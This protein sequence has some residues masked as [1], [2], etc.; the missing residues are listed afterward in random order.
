MTAPQ[1]SVLLPAEADTPS[2]RPP[3]RR[4]P[5]VRP[6]GPGPLSAGRQT[7]D[8]LLSTLRERQPDLHA[9]LTGVADTARGGGARAGHDP[10]R[11]STRSRGPRSC[12]TSARW[13]SPT[14]SCDKPGPL[15]DEEWT[16]HAP[17]HDH[18]RAHPRRGP[19]LVPVAR[20]VRSSHERWDGAGYPDGLAGEEIPL[21]RPRRVRVRRLRRDGLRPPLPQRA[22]ARARRSRS[23]GAAPGPSSTRAWSTPSR[24]SWCEA[25]APCAAH[26]ANPSA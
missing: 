16:L 1:G 18:R 6:E 20:L 21:G 19:A 8:V 12:T 9:H 26:A 11:R 5:H 7:R 2:P 10:P 25:A 17:P 4:P 15:D 14:R 24:W 22:D 3:A 13:R 23:C